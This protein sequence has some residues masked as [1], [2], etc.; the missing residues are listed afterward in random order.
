MHSSIYAC[1]YT[2]QLA[3]MHTCTLAYIAYL[4]TCIHAYLHSCI[5]AYSHTLAYW[6]ACI[7][8]YMWCNITNI[9]NKDITSNNT[10]ASVGLLAT[11]QGR[12]TH[13][14]RMRARPN[15]KFLIWCATRRARSREP[16]ARVCVCVCGRRDFSRNASERVG[17]RLVT[18]ISC[19]RLRL[20]LLTR[21]RSLW[22]L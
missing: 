15:H 18:Y 11:H 4:H 12:E 7:H 6:H 5:L 3:Y 22:F 9:M 1:M 19:G 2:W 10:T 21:M 8:A 16:C 17:T 13:S 20:R 14:K